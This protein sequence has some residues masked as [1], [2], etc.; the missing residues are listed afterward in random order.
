LVTGK[1]EATLL[2][3]RFLVENGYYCCYY[4]GTLANDSI[5]LEE[6]VISLFY[7]R[8]GVEVLLK[9]YVAVELAGFWLSLKLRLDD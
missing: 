2:T 4:S 9:F 6:M 1:G 8:R 3:A 5:F 7:L